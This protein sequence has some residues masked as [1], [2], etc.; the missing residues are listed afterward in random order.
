MS[1]VLAGL[2]LAASA[3]PA[4]TSDTSSFSDPY[5][6][7]LTSVGP[8]GYWGYYYNGNSVAAITDSQARYMISEQQASLLHEEVRRQKLDYRR[9][10][11]EFNV[12]RRGYLLQKDEEFRKQVEG[13]ALR[14]A[15]DNPGTTDIFSGKA[16]NMLVDDLRK[17]GTT[18]FPSPIEAEWLAHVRL[19]SKADRGLGIFAKDRIH[20]PPLLWIEFQDTCKH[21]QVQVDD[22]KL[23]LT[24][25]RDIDPSSTEALRADVK[26]LRDKLDAGSRTAAAGDSLWCDAN[27]LTARA[28]LKGL[29][30]AAYDIGNNAEMASYLRRPNAKTVGEL[31]LY[32]NQ[33]GLIFTEATPGD[34]RFYSAMHGALANEW[35][36]SR[37]DTSGRQ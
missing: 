35:R 14:T 26:R 21:I 25:A 20:W 12:W 30:Q 16:L 23:A 19:G 4:Q 9:R 27:C 5:K 17:L 2:L 6:S 22:I 15:A 11:I 29:Y 34:Q 32:M 7:M 33:Q 1:T 18:D 36:R 13:V 8:G 28:F 24:S 37:A 3:V 31:I 10:E